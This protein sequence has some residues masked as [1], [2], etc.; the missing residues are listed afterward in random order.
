LRVNFRRELLNTALLA[1]GILSAAMGIKGFLLSSHF[2]DG[3]VTGVS[4]LLSAITGAPLALLLPAINLPFI[5]LGFHQM[6]AA[7]ALRST[8]SVAGLAAALALI[9]FPDVTPD[10][11]LTAVFGGFFL[12]AGIGLAIRGGAVLDGTEIAALLI[13]RR[14]DVLR[15]GDVILSFNA[16]L[17]VSAIAVL[18]VEPALYSILTYLAAARTLDFVIHGID[19]YTA[20]TIVSDHNGQIRQRI[21][22]A[23]GR[24][25]TIYRGFGGMSGRE[26]DILYCVVTRL[27]IG[28]VKAIVREI[29]PEAFIVYHALAGAEGGVVKTRGFH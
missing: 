9:P 7:F 3:G 19:E 21:M 15:V 23:L 6:G 8:V 26:R 20:V 27:E 11:V 16:V 17:F 13:S 2:I 22:H 12:G 28:K 5:V 24:G 4:M 10:L 18:G 1:A 14:G 25:V 29:D